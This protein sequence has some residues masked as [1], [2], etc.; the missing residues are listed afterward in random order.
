ML[1]ASV[2]AVRVA[3]LAGGVGG[4]AVRSRGRRGEGC[5]RRNLRPDNPH[6]RVATP[7]LCAL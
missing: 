3:N 7:P 5:E 2:C 6:P 4:E 1:E